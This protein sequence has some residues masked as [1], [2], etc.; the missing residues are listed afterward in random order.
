MQG[1]QLETFG[2]CSLNL[3]S[4]WLSPNGRVTK[5]RMQATDTHS[6]GFTAQMLLLNLET[7]PT[8]NTTGANGQHGPI[9]L[10]KQRSEQ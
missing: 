8:V 10:Q 1:F 3:G 9:T 5:P 7:V 6:T 2:I 4:S